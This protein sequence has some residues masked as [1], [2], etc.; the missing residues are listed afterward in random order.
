ME[1]AVTKRRVQSM[2]KKI[3]AYDTEYKAITLDMMISYIIQNYN[4]EDGVAG[5]PMIIKID[6]EDLKADIKNKINLLT[7]D[8]VI[9]EVNSSVLDD[10]D[11]QDIVRD[12]KDDGYQIC[13]EI[14]KEDKY[15]SI[16]RSLANIV[17]F[18][19]KE[20]DKSQFGLTNQF[21]CK[22]LAYNV[23]TPD[24]FIL[25]EAANIEYYEGDY[26]Y[27]TIEMDIPN[28]GHSGANF[29]SV[30]KLLNGDN[31][32]P[33]VQELAAVI[34][35]DALLTAQVIRLSNSIYFSAKHRVENIEEAITNIGIERLKKWLL[36]LQFNN[37]DSTKEVT[38]RES[39]FRG[40]FCKKIITN[41]INNKLSPNDAY[42]IGLLSKLEALTGKSMS[43]EIKTLNLGDR[44]ERAL[45]YRDGIGGELLNLVIAFEEGN[46]EQIDHYI[47]SFHL[48]RAKL[49][50][51]YYNSLNRSIT[52]WN[53]LEKLYKK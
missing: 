12:I 48:N 36:L 33:S 9:I 8:S 43:G 21:S 2:T 30:I 13:I 20:I 11:N 53:E 47:K 34:S 32:T 38:L 3:V 18:N 22:K 17:K 25:A 23:D 42:I 37:P 1:N 29:L 35:R 41:S 45:I 26:I 10:R 50:K 44:L 24:D 31:K 6:K 4:P 27:K 5:V 16:A 7:T 15:F 51:D 46:W 40:I 39:Y 52:E 19:I 49:F 14:N 28:Y